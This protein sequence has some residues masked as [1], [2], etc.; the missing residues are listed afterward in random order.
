MIYQ[1]DEVH[2][3][4]TVSIQLAELH[5]IDGSLV[6]VIKCIKHKFEISKSHLDADLLECHHEL[7][8]VKVTTIVLIYSA[9]CLSEV[10]VLFLDAGMDL[11]HDFLKS[12]VH[13]S[14]QLLA[15]ARFKPGLAI[16]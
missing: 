6:I 10:T 14:G 1:S 3:C 13:E 7:F 12:L 15:R 16:V 9:E 2:K 4:V 8:E 5:K 11:S